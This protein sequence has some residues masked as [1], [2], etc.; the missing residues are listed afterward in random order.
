MSMCTP[1]HAI[2]WRTTI[3]RLP[4]RRIYTAPRLLR[5][6][7]LLPF[8]TISSLPRLLPALDLAN[9][10]YDA[11]LMFEMDFDDVLNAQAWD[12]PQSDSTSNDQSSPS[13]L[14]NPQQFPF[15]MPSTINPLL[16]ELDN[17]Q[18]LQHW[19][20][21][22][23]ASP[24]S[25]PPPSPLSPEHKNLPPLFGGPAAFS[26]TL[27][28]KDSSYGSPP[29]MTLNSGVDFTNIDPS[30]RSAHTS[31][32][33]PNLQYPI[34]IPQSVSSAPGNSNPTADFTV[35]GGGGQPTPIWATQLFEFPRSPAL[36]VPM[37]S[38]SQQVTQPQTHLYA[39]SPQGLAFP[40]LS[41]SP[42]PSPSSPGGGF[43]TLTAAYSP[44]SAGFAHPHHPH[45]YH[46][47]TLSHSHAQHL[48]HLSRNHSRRPQLQAFQPA[49]APSHV[50]MSTIRPRVRSRPTSM[51][52]FTP[53][54]NGVPLAVEHARS[55]SHRASSSESDALFNPAEA[56]SRVGSAPTA[57][58]VVDQQ[59]I[60]RQDPSSAGGLTLT[61]TEPEAV[62]LDSPAL[63]SD[64]DG[65]IRQKRKKA[66]K[67]LSSETP[68]DHDYE[69]ERSRRTSF[70]GAAGS[71]I[72]E[73]I[74]T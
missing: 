28:T 49:S 35:G 16:S 68:F 39:T 12:T 27:D 30:L 52:M 41:V 11:G 20:A 5:P 56:F 25:M 2:R 72:A 22:L 36:N 31:S 74:G 18:Y 6:P 71:D 50:S 64:P 69:Q 46:T 54:S 58:G 19:S 38:S 42:S 70:S 48:H 9:M 8:P 10:D 66:N 13:H 65:T 59:V 55:Y 62:F 40:S 34:S 45:P 33:V 37:A 43:S 7:H 32:T 24:A 21:G 61:K 51:N 47:H 26:P 29:F 60:S 14:S 1:M 15:S 73:D 44:P 17:D 67:R 23:E 63:E 57:V 53:S 3:P 4:A